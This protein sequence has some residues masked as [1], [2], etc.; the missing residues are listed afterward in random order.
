LLKIYVP[1]VDVMEPETQGTA[2]RC[3]E[4]FREPEGPRTV[5]AFRFCQRSVWNQL[6]AESAEIAAVP[7]SGAQVVWF[8][9][10]ASVCRTVLLF[11]P[12]PQPMADITQIL[13]QIESGDPAAAEQLLPLIYDG[14]AE[15]RGSLDG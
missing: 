8:L 12:E 9:S 14:I 15:A 10:A 13:C 3:G 11:V 1:F 6:P 2:T 7:G 5:S 4:Q